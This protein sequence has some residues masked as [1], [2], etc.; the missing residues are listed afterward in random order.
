MLRKIFFCN[1]RGV[2]FM[3]LLFFVLSFCSILS[4]QLCSPL[5]FEVCR[6]LPDVNS[7]PSNPINP[8]PFHGYYKVK[9]KSMAGLLPTAWNVNYLAFSGTISVNE[10]TSRINLDLTKLYSQTILGSANPYYQY[11]NVTEDGQ[12]DWTVGSVSP[13]SQGEQGVILPIQDGQTEIELFT[14]VVDGVP[15]DFVNFSGD[16]PNANWVGDIKDC[17]YYNCSGTI[18]VQGCTSPSNYLIPFPW[19]PTCSNPQKTVTFELETVQVGA[20]LIQVKLNNL[21]PFQIVRKSDLVIHIQPQMNGINNLVLDAIQANG[22]P[23]IVLSKKKDGPNSSTDFYIQLKGFSAGTSSINILTILVGGQFNLSQGVSFECSMSPGRGVFADMPQTICSLT[24]VTNTLTIPGFAACPSSINVSPTRYT[25]PGCTLGV[26]YTIRHNEPNPINLT[27]LKL[28]FAFKLTNGNNS[29]GSPTTTLPCPSCGSLTYNATADTWEYLYEQN[30]ALSLPNIS[31]VL[32]PFNINIDCIS[33]YVILAEATPS[34][35]SI[36][37]LGVTFDINQWPACDPS[38]KGSIIVDK[39]GAAAL[40][41]LYKVTLESNSDPSYFMVNDEDCKADY[42]FCPDP[43]KAPFQIRLAS[44]SPNIYLCGVTTY[45]LV[46]ISKHLLGIAPITEP[47]TLIAADASLLPLNIPLPSGLSTFDIAQIRKCIL[48][49]EP[50]FGPYSAPSWWYFR[51]GYTFKPLPDLFDP[52][53]AGSNI[54]PVPANGLGSYGDFFA[55]KVG[56]VNHTCDCGMRP[57]GNESVRPFLKVSTSNIR[58]EGNNVYVPIWSDAP[59]NLIAAQ[60]GF[61][62]DPSLLSL[63]S[64]IPNPE[65]EINDFN[66]GVNNSTKGELRFAW[67]PFDGQTPLPKQALLFSLQFE[68][69]DKFEMPSAPLFWTSE[70]ILQSLVYQEDGSEFSTRL[71]WEERGRERSPSL[72]LVV[73]PNPFE[74]RMTAFVYV[75]KPVKATISLSDGKGFTYSQQTVELQSGDNAVEIRTSASTQPGVYILSIVADGQRIQR[76]IVKI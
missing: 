15:G 73:S 8:G 51:D 76:R 33:Y 4:A 20:R 11:L 12:V 10:F 29:P 55:V 63:K 54:S 40:A 60:T 70:D 22:G 30:T 17:N 45:D 1:S 74:E 9:L 48:G 18:P 57:G 50:N 35:G 25:G 56:D 3:L 19:P 53:Y 47:K 44:S 5:Y 13:C 27:Y 6:I 26:K 69:K 37:A 42:S 2:A 75:E 23:E 28:L 38:V 32:V 58:R 68:L 59:F 64:V 39:G 52:P 65:L 61:R 36:C 14:I 24:G 46:V 62:F 41:P 71:N 16:N 49:I 72:A 7:Y 34:G 66:F 67:S 43:V 21:I 31:E